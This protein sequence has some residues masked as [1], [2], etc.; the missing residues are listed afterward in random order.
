MFSLPPFQLE[1]DNKI[2]SS[3][4]I[5]SMTRPQF[6]PQFYYYQPTQNTTDDIVE[7]Y[8]SK[9]IQSNFDRL[10]K[11]TI[12]EILYRTPVQDVF[13]YCQAYQINICDDD[14]FWGKYI[15][16]NNDI[17]YL[18]QVLPKKLH[19][20]D[21]NH[22][23][24]FEKVIEI[25][26]DTMYT[27]TY[28]DKKFPEYS[29]L[30]LIAL[31]LQTSKLIPRNIRDKYG[32]PSNVLFEFISPYAIVSEYCEYQ[33]DFGYNWIQ[34]GNLIMIPSDSKTFK[35]IDPMNYNE[36]IQLIIGR[37]PEPEIEYEIIMD[38]YVDGKPLYNL[39]TS[40]EKTYIRND[41]V[42]A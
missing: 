39:I 32:I 19:A 23:S 20:L 3:P 1:P 18:N 31:F 16:Y 42:F 28:L 2:K 37:Q 14:T 30:S 38:I 11:E 25:A 27:Y 40:V 7:Y 26:K 13:K 21:T 6:N 22:F 34:L 24:G 5:E 8:P 17:D 10:P 33:A 36:E 35:V 12:L 15:K 4:M 9:L 41:R 29:E